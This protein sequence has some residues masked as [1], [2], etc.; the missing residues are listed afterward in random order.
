M[1]TQALV[2]ALP[3]ESLGLKNQGAEELLHENYSKVT[4]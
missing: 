3:P 1:K 4:D 2:V